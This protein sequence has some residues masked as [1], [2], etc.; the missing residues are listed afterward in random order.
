MESKT[1]DLC[2]TILETSDT[3]AEGRR[4]VAHS[5]VL[6][7]SAWGEWPGRCDL[8]FD[9]PTTLPALAGAA[10]LRAS[11]IPAAAC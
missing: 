8:Y 7:S 4:E 2:V 11:A 6:P 10:Q 3:E 9:G 5:G 1:D